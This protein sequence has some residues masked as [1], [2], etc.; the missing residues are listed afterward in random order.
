M[1]SPHCA[2]GKSEAE[3]LSDLPAPPPQGKVKAGT[4]THV[5]VSLSPPCVPYCRSGLLGS[6]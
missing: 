5:C 1:A 2:D 6:D 3:H 4:G